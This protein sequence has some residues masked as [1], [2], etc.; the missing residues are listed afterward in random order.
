MASN[1]SQLAMVLAPPS[2]ADVGHGQLSTVLAQPS[3]EDVGLG[4]AKFEGDNIRRLFVQGVQKSDGPAS[5][6]CK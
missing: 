6:L 1:Y 4:L 2:P 3:P 5:P